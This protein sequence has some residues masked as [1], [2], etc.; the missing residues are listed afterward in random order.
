MHPL[1]ARWLLA[2][3]LVLGGGLLGWWLGL[4]W[5]QAGG[6]AILGA[7]AGLSLF[8]MQDALRAGRLLRWLRGT[9]A[10]AAPRD[11]GLW[12]ELGYRV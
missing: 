1:L 9:Q 7:V 8:G 2:L 12:G 3:A 10:D 11:T 5:R 6:G 4:V